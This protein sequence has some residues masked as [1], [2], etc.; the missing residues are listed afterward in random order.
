MASPGEIKAID[1]SFARIS[2][3]Q[4]AMNGV[5]HVFRYEAW[6][7]NGKVIQKPEYDDDVAHGITVH[8]NWETT[9]TRPLDGPGAGDVDGTESARQNGVLG[10]TGSVITSL[11]AD[12]SALSTAQLDTAIAYWDHFGS[13]VNKVGV[14]GGA[15]LI[16]YV[17]SKRGSAFE[18]WQTA[19]WS[20]QYLS[21]HADYY[22]RIG[23]SWSLPGVPSNAYDEDVVIHP[24]IVIVKPPPAPVETPMLT[25]HYNVSNPYP[26]VDVLACPTGGFWQL[27]ADGSIE[28]WL[29]AP[30][31]GGANGQAYFAGRIAARLVPYQ[32]N[33]Y[34]IKDTAW[35]PAKP[36]AEIYNYAPK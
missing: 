8:I 28:A 11:D 17:Y 16:D 24:G 32:V 13:H 15:R 4:L 21:P 35:D 22:Q 7:P 6:L 30:Y 26:V 5:K 27:F 18:Y 31:L 36:D 10:Y 33:G 3:A 20:G 12:P 14:Y 19:A 2:A 1:F 29:G 34:S 23:H 25:P 9:A